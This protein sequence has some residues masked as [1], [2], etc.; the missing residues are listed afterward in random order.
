MIVIESLKNIGFE[1]ESHCIPNDDRWL[2]VEAELEDVGRYDEANSCYRYIFRTYPFRSMEL[3]RRMTSLSEKKAQW[4]RD[5]NDWRESDNNLLSAL[6]YLDY[7]GYDC[8]NY[9][10]IN[11]RIMNS[12]SN[13]VEYRVKSAKEMCQNIKDSYME[14]INA[15]KLD[16]TTRVIGFGRVSSNFIRRIDDECIDKILFLEEYE[17]DRSDISISAMDNLLEIKLVPYPERPKSN[18]KIAEKVIDMIKK[19]DMF[20]SVI[21]GAERLIFVTAL[22]S[23]GSYALAELAKQ[24]PK[25]NV[26]TAAFLQF[27]FQFEGRRRY[28]E[29]NRLCRAIKEN[30]AYLDVLELDELRK[31]ECS[32]RQPMDLHFEMYYDSTATKILDYIYN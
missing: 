20:S 11:E 23:V 10:M 24:I 15:I 17:K 13:S 2:K 16:H 18:E 27:P 31:L 3:F 29:A 22:P 7:T 12:L 5:N 21:E 25:T 30:I 4:A 14:K 32:E 1:M 6:S 8:R 26:E 19:R 9:N 28:D